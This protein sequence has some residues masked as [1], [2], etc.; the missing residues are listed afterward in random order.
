MNN[1]ELRGVIVPVCANYDP[2]I[3]LRLY[4]AG[5]RGDTSEVARLV[6]EIMALRETLL[7][8]GPCWLTGIKYA[9]AALG[10]G[11]GKP[12]S[13]LEPVDA[14]RKTRIDALV[15]KGMK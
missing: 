14:Q 3:F 13:P 15:N 2:G 7:L 5:T 6:A 1:H 12:V 4:D 10:I 11:S 8:S 9:M